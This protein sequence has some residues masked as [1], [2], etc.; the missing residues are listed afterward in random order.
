M[1][2]TKILVEYLAAGVIICLAFIILFACGFPVETQSLLAWLA[3][4][5]T[6][7]GIFSIFAAVGSTVIVYA[8]GVISEYFGFITFDPLYTRRQKDRYKIFYRTQKERLAKSPLGFYFNSPGEEN[9]RKIYGEMRFFVMAHNALLSNEIDTQINRYRLIRVTFWADVVIL[10][11]LFIQMIQKPTI[12]LMAGMVLII[13]IAVL[14]FF[15]IRSRFDRYFKAI[16]RAYL[17]LCLEKSGENNMKI[18][19]NME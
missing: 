3:Q 13:F 18:H 14:N 7:S 5:D 16:E 17:V 12:I 11:A 8:I 4:Q 9:A 19:G 10:L 1:E 6:S 2:T 15:A